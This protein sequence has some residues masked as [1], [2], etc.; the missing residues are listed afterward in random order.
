MT[1]RSGIEETTQARRVGCYFG[2]NV[3]QANQAS[4]ETP[5]ETN[6]KRLILL[7]MPKVFNSRTRWAD[8][9][10]AFKL[11]GW[12]KD[13][14]VDPLRKSAALTTSKTLE[15]LPGQSVFRRYYPQYVA[16]IGILA[17]EKA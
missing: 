11:Y 6:P 9:D 5:T 4:F 16:L 17:R 8:S 7:G 15:L 13:I 1:Q 10:T 12:Q 3:F 14:R 2:N